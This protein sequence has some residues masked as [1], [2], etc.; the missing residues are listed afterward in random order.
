MSETKRDIIV[1]GAT[2]F[3]GALVAEYLL[4]S[5]GV[6][7]ELNWAVAGRNRDKLEAL[8]QRLGPNA[9]KLPIIVADSMD[10]ESMR[11][12]ASQTRVMLTTVGPYAK[13]GTALLEAC[14]EA[15]TDY[16]DLC[17]EVQ[18]LR[19]MM[20]KHQA[21]ARETGARLLH[22]CGYDSIPSDIGTWFLQNHAKKRFGEYCSS[23]TMVVKAA[24][25]GASGGTVA[26]MVNII[27]ETRADRDAARFVAMPYSLNPPD[28][29]DGPRVRDQSGPEYSELLKSWTA[30]FVMAISNTRIVR[31]SNALADFIYGKDFVYRETITT[32]RGIGGWFKAFV[33]SAGIGSILLGVAF[34]PTRAL[35]T[36][37]VLPK[38]GEGP[39]A[40]SRANGFFKH[41]FTGIASDHR[42]L[43][44]R[45]TGDRDPGYGSTSKM[46]AETAVCLAQD[47]RPTG[48]GFWTTATAVAEPLH[49]RLVRNAGLTFDVIDD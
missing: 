33:I 19:R 48:G 14:V 42:R 16:C 23:V 36:R 38:P 15:G 29:R 34:S 13:Y 46:L 5:Y 20:D 18:W 26:S 28:R 40:E 31:R 10:S 43:R 6:G 44:V 39:D 4:A 3:T 9:D 21:R 8:R 22:C 11:S 49:E 30:P 7:G 32:G 12:V 2:G 1:W 35:L 25:G 37:F 24:R 45:V 47:E 17:A 27:K 41:E